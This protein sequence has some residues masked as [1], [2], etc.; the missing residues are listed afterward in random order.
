MNNKKEYIAHSE[1]QNGVIQTMKEHSVGVGKF[2]REFALSDSFAELYEFC[3]LIHD[4]GK[5]S[6]AFQKRI[7]GEKDQVRHSIYGAIFAK[8]QSLM[9]VV[10]PVFGHHA[11]LPDNPKMRQ[12]IITE[13]NTDNSPYNEICRAWM[14]EI[15]Q[16]AN[17][18]NDRVFHDLTDILI[19]ELF[20]RLLYSSLV[21]ADS[22]DTERHFCEDRF[23]AR[24]N[25]P[26]NTEVLLYRLRQKF[27]SFQNNQEE[28]VS[29]IAQ[30][31]DNVRKY[32]ESK[33]SLP[34]GFFSLTLPTGLGK[35]LCSMNWALHHA[36]H[37]KNI[38][39]I[40]IVLP[41]ISIID[42]TAEVYKT[43]F[44]GE[45]GCDY[46]LEHHS[47]VIYTEDE[48]KD[49]YNPKQLATE[50]WDYPI[51][52]TTSVQFFE[53]LFDNKRSACRKLHNI[54]DSVIIFDEIQT[55][56]LN[57]TEPT[58]TMLDNL[59]KLCR[60]SIL[61]CTAT[62]PDFEAREGFQGV[63]KIESL[64]ENPKLIF[65]STRRVTYHPL[66]QYEEISISE[67]ADNVIK[68]NK[69][70]LVVFNT[71]KKTRLFFNEMKRCG[72]YNLFHL[73][74]NMCP[75]HRKEVIRTIRQALRQG[76]RIIVSSTQLIE[77]GVDMDF[78]TVYRELAPL[79]SIIQSA[80][81]CNREGQLKDDNGSMIKGDVYLFA[82]TESGQP[83]KEYQS[84]LEFAQL[85]YNGNEE[86]L[87][88]HDFYSHYYRELVKNFAN[89]DKLHITTD[90]KKF[91]FQTVADKYKIIDNNT[92]S[93]FVYTYNQ[94]SKELYN[95]VKNKDFITRRERQEISQYCV[96]IYDEF[97]EKNSTLIGHESSGMLIWYGSYDIDLGLP[98]KDEFNF[99]I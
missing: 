8:E 11:G 57:V 93:I 54:Q 66:N 35:T 98:Y 39:R 12:A 37:H 42:Q 78:P 84:F 16:K 5:Y 85:L 71:K 33:A 86:K 46:V 38:K 13:K 45:T 64:V 18:P 10:F 76:K 28:G 30:L 80:G 61:F 29:T 63:S 43:I 91:L 24:R 47:N 83:S 68:S 89:T 26:L 96:Q 17:I 36:Q 81:R 51:I 4:I 67:L 25:Y 21:D 27:E 59:Q 74:T 32:A 58:L 70:A 72:D 97:R 55:L 69:S 3:G 6:N 2:M 20:V 15:G 92:Q 48:D 95:Q 14:E 62:Q 75:A 44:N 87:Y 7:I 50:N 40:I 41:F 53:S 22:L 49:E 19:Q 77:A 65:E 9:E 82:L 1:N 79:E 23:E 88:T 60:C 99:V 56:P 31:R 94:R 90:R 52:I 73:S 34:Q